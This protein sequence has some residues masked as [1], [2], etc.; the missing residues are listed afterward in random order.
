MENKKYDTNQAKQFLRQYKTAVQK[1]RILQESIETIR[2]MAM[3]ITVSLDPDK[4]Q[5]SAKVHDP[6]AEAAA[7]IADTEQLL[8]RAKADVARTL[9]EIT[10]V[11]M[12]VPDPENHLQQ[13][14]LLHY[15]KLFNWEQTAEAMGYS[16]RHILR[17]HGE[18]LQAVSKIM[19]LY[20]TF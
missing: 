9:K 7:A 10:N 19:S 12:A 13:L 14:L 17:L 5:S 2:E 11:I 20:V 6:I 8:I 18:A 16:T 1:Y 4:V 3:N 15:I